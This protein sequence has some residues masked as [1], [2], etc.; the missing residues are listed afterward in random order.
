[1]SIN[2][3]HF[4]S[5]NELFGSAVGDL[6]LQ[7]TARRI[8]SCVRDGDLVARSSGDEFAVVLEHLSAATEEAA[9][10]AGSI[11]QRILKALEEPFSL[12]GRDC[13][14]TASIGITILSDP[15]LGAEDILQQ[16]DIAIDHAKVAGRNTMRFFSPALQDAINEHKTIE[17]SLR[18]GIE[19]DKLMLYYQPQVRG[20]G[21]VGAEALVRWNHPARGLLFPGAFIPLAEESGLILPLGA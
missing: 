17:A 6:F 16:G 8:L 10:K 21:L 15:C 3:D 5:V 20:N 19:S 4:R 9:A 11:A 18:A 2:L 7:E 13:R 12:A 1:L 14:C